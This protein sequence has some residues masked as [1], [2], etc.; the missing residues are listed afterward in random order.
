MA[1]QKSDE[2]SIRSYYKKVIALRADSDV[3]KSGS[4]VPLKISKR[5]FAYKRELNGEAI[6]VILNFSDRFKKVKH[7]GEILISSYSKTRITGIMRPYEAVIL[8]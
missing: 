5:I 4:F 8:K 3:L 6:T 7:N 2:N 1:A